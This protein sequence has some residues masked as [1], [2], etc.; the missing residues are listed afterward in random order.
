MFDRR[1]IQNFDWVLMVLLLFLAAI[2]ILNLYSATYAIREVGGAQVFAKQIYWFLIGFFVF[3]LMTTFNYYSAV[4]GKGHI[5]LT[6]VVEPGTHL[7][8]TVRTGKDCHF[9]GTCQVFQ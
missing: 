3:L 7:L 9:D 2:S 4:C 5:R 6:E 1:L 8:S